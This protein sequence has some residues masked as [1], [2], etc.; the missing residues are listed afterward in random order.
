MS[1]HT[2]REFRSTDGFITA[3]WASFGVAVFAV[4]ALENGPMRFFEDHWLLALMFALGT[5]TTS[6]LAGMFAFSFEN[7]RRNPF[8]AVLAAFFVAEIVLGVGVFS[9]GTGHVLLESIRAG[10]IAG[11][12]GGSMLV[13]PLAITAYGVMFTGPL[14]LG[15][16]LTIWVRERWFNRG[17]PVIEQDEV[18]RVMS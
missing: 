9:G 16:G 2:K 1:E 5:Y 10:Q 11:D 12:P 15:L 6:Y 8:L 4:A 18:E 17:E 13:A 3:F 14:S 7:V